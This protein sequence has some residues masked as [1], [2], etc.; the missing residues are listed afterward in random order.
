MND[1]PEGLTR[2]GLVLDVTYLHTPAITEVCAVVL[3]SL[4]LQ[5]KSSLT[6]TTVGRTLCK[7]IVWGI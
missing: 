1:C 7:S 6:L 4:R 3:A 2:L 5:D